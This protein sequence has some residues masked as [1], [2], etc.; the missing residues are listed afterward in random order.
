MKKFITLSFLFC[1]ALFSYQCGDSDDNNTATSQKTTTANN[2]NNK[3][4]KRNKA[5]AK[6]EAVLK[7]NIKNAENLR[8]FFEQHSFFDNVNDIQASGS[9]DADGNFNLQLPM[10]EPGIYR[11]RIGSKRLFLPIDESTNE[12]TLSGDLATLSTKTIKVTGAKNI[13]KNLDVFFKLQSRQINANNA[14]AIIESTENPVLSLMVAMAAYGQ[15]PKYIK[16]YKSIVQ[17]IQS[18]IPGSDYAK[19]SKGFIAQLEREANNPIQIGKA[20]PDITY[21]DPNGKNRSLSSLKGKVVLL[22]FWASWCG[23]CRRENP[24]VVRIYNKYHKKGFE[25]FSVSLDKPNG[26]SRWISAIEKDGLIWP[27]HVSDLK[28]WSSAPARLYKV[29]SI[30]R[31]FLIDRNGNIADMNV[32]G[33]ALEAAVKELLEKK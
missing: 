4:T 28:G 7:G 17:Q 32:R 1:L 26:K 31:T 8:I 15:N 16:Q 3:T 29:R 23:P 11:V 20:A 9:I 6:K 10:I 21:P 18:T 12:I 5:P 30:P 33:A 14:N 25:V 27:N 22:D 19:K 24:N 13:D 2:P